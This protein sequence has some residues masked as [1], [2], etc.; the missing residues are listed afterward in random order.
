[1]YGLEAGEGAVVIDVVKEGVGVANLGGEVDG[2]SVG[3]RGVGEERGGQK[4]EGK[5]N[6]AMQNERNAGLRWGLKA[7]MH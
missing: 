5:E 7:Y 2:I 3:I 6:G 4:E 1:L